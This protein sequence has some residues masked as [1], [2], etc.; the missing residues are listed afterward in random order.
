MTTVNDKNNAIVK[1][2]MIKKTK[3]HIC[4]L[5]KNN[6]IDISDHQE[7]INYIQS[8]PGVSIIEEAGDSIVDIGEIDYESTM[9]LFNFLKKFK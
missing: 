2:K 8:L 4:Q 3:A 7:I 5:F 6:E 9:R 1:E